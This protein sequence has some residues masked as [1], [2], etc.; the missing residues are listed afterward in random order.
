VDRQELAAMQ[1]KTKPANIT[2]PRR[3]AAKRIKIDP[4]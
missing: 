2:S 4:S 1:V 3:L